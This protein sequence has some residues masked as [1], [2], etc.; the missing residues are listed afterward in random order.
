MLKRESRAFYGE[1][2]PVR[3]AAASAGKEDK[4]MAK[5]KTTVYFCQEC[6]Y[7]SAKWMGQCPACHEWNS[8]VEETVE[9][10]SARGSR[11]ADSSREAKAVPLSQIEM[12]QEQRVSTGMKELDRVLGGGIVQGSLVLVGGDPGIGKSTLL[13]QVCRNLAEH[14]VKVL[15]ISGEESLQQIKI[16]AERIGTFGDSL[17]LLCETNLDA[18]RRVIDREK[19]EIVVIDS[20]QTMYNEDV[21]SAP[22]SVSQV[23]ESTGTLMQIAKGLGISIF[24]V[25]HVTK[26]GV[27]AGPRV[28]EHMVDTVLYFEGDRHAAYRIL[29]GVKNR[30][31][32]TNE[33]G[34]FEMRGDGLTEVENPSEFMLSGKPEG[35]SGSVVACSMEGTRPILLEIQALVCHSNFGMPRRT[36]AGT[37]FNRVNLLMAV[38]EKRLGLSL[39]NCDAYINIAG[40]IRMN[41]PAIDLGLVLAIV[42]SYKDR[43]IDE[44]TICFGEVG[45]SGEVRAVSMAEQR[46]LEAKK[47]GFET[48]IVN[49]NPETVSTDYD[50]SDKL[51]FEPLTLE[52]V[53]SIYEKEKPLGVI[54]QFGGQT[55]LNLAADLEKNGV[56][57]LG[58]APS[59]IDLAEDRD[60]FRAMMDKLEIPMPEAGMATTVEEAVEIAG[61]IGY[62]VMVRPSYVLGGRG[63][64]VVYDDVAMADYMKAAV[65]VTP[66]R[67]ILIDR[68]LNHALECESDA[69]CDGTNAFV[70]AVMEH[71][72]LAGVHSGDSA[73]VIPSVH[74]SKEN[75]E[76]IKEY[77]RKIAEEMHVQGLMNMQYAIENGKVFVLEANPRAS[78]TVPLVSKVCNV[79][80][81]PIATEIITRELTGKES[82]VPALEEKVI[83]YYGVKEAAFPFNMFPEVDPLLG[84]EM[85]STGEVLGLSESYGEAFYKAQEAVQSKLPLSGT[86]LISVNR[87][88]KAEV[89][90]V[91]KL[92]HENNFRII[93]TEG[94]C[95]L[96]NEAGI[97]AEKVKKL[98]EGRPNVLDEITNGKVDIIVNSPVGKDSVYDDSYL[99]KAA[100]K[101][102]IPYCTTMAAAM[103]AATGIHAVNNHD[104]GKIASLQELHGR[105]K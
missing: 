30:F 105:I 92:F 78:R 84:P 19:P 24:I 64:E 27:V 31:G 89:V 59:V 54:A 7:E 17:S 101:G 2:S 26:E 40:G 68:F 93:A 14:K 6:G 8:F 38:L 99:R 1:K 23:R 36:A 77:T 47:L 66:D 83:P 81:V 96:I 58:T 73:C 74:I 39:G 103:A 21:S 97:P 75:V 4:N 10:K 45:L 5:G 25:G 55:P 50:T 52:D 18:I 56:R 32:S 86:V 70:P 35:A 100:I 49:C 72:E 60:Q 34:V 43:P 57:I 85:R 91:A 61:K 104:G 22:G 37:D 69:I 48:I 65:G 88:D 16:R 102:R 67:P 90:E 62:P 87:K 13:L 9:K 46:V 33:I 3:A 76:T 20:I 63:M 12:T 28:L 94:T 11:S 53:L 51:Y 80:M 15:Y 95:Q 29:R 98:C 42:S 82:P 44:K 41:E 71:I 79:R